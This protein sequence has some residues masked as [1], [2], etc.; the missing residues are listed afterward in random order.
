[1]CRCVTI[2][3]FA[4]LKSGR[5]SHSPL[6]SSFPSGINAANIIAFFGPTKRLFHKTLFVTIKLSSPR[7]RRPPKAWMA[8]ETMS[9][10]PPASRGCKFYRLQG[11]S[12]RPSSF[13]R[14]FR[15]GR[16]QPFEGGSF[17]RCPVF[18]L[19]P[20][21]RCLPSAGGIGVIRKEVVSEVK[22]DRP[23]GQLV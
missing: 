23:P 2:F 4:L 5:E 14:R 10:L 12:A 17:L 22:A 8:A 13:R 7:R 3:R 1:V 20:S 21:R 18:M 6:N 15:R 11:R 9:P 16:F 19:S